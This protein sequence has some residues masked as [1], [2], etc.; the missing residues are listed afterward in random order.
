MKA[1]QRV[2]SIVASAIFLWRGIN[3]LIDINELIADG[4]I[5][6]I[7][8]TELLILLFETAVMLLLGIFALFQKKRGKLLNGCGLLYI[9]YLVVRF[10]RFLPYSFHVIAI[11]RLVLLT[12]AFFLSQK[13]C[14]GVVFDTKDTASEAAK[15]QIQNQMQTMIYDEQLRDGILTQ[16]EYDQIMRNKQ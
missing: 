15:I 11:M 6:W 8:I 10:L 14:G 1:T 9:A 12:T 7:P 5:F 2:I 13:V 4:S 3:C 16:E